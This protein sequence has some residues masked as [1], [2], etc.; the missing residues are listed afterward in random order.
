ML[1]LGDRGLL[2]LVLGNGLRN[3]IEASMD[4]DSRDPPGV[5]IAWDETNTD[6]W[7]VILDRG[8]G[9]PAGS[10][11]AFEAGRTSKPGHAGLGLAIAKQAADSLT[12][13]IVLKPR[14]DG[15]TAYE[16]SWPKREVAS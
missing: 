3:A 16:L 1:V 9:L 4:V 10:H 11:Y 7:V 8:A 14:A 2:S 15:G 6:Y 5:V 13:R 12:G